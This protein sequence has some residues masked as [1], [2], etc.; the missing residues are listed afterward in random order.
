MQ[1]FIATYGLWILVVLALIAII[2]FLFR[3]K[4]ADKTIAAPPPQ[5]TSEKPGFARAPPT[6]V[7]PAPQPKAAEPV[8]PAKP[9]S[10][11]EPDN[12]LKIKGIGPK[13]NGILI[14]LGVTRYE[15]IASWTATDLAEIDRH[16][17]NFAGRP[18]RD[19]WMDQAS[20]LARGDVAGFEAKYGKL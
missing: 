1:D 18:S 5:A 16:L 2:A 11:G 10:S 14:G 13:V 4:G 15:Q 9:R 6:P 20:Y 3:G 8:A 17:G 19:Q 12:L 7:E